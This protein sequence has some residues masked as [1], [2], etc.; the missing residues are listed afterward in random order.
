MLRSII[1]VVRTKKNRQEMAPSTLRKIVKA[2]V[3]PSLNIVNV[4]QGKVTWAKGTP[5]EPQNKPRIMQVNPT[6]KVG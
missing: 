4:N 3:M 5:P 2:K 1:D 6:I